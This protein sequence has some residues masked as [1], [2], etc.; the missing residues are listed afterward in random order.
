MLRTWFNYLRL[1]ENLHL[2][3]DT[4]A[5]KFTSITPVHVRSV[6]STTQNIQD[7]HSSSIFLCFGMEN[8]WASS[9]ST[10]MSRHDAFSKFLK[11][12]FIF[13]KSQLN[14]LCIFYLPSNEVGRYVTETWWNHVYVGQGWNGHVDVTRCRNKSKI[15]RS[16]IGHVAKLPTMTMLFFLSPHPHGMAHLQGRLVWPRSTF[17]PQNAL[18]AI[19]CS[20]C[21]LTIWEHLTSSVLDKGKRFI[22]CKVVTIIPVAHGDRVGWKSVD[23]ITSS[24]IA[25]HP[26]PW[27]LGQNKLWKLAPSKQWKFNNPYRK[28]M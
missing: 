12:F 3:S 26:L 7:H 21:R 24:L 17:H 18:R 22:C 28:W 2:K 27:H 6:C 16:A 14:V 15:K 11:F 19:V 23:A 25:Q 13:G 9:C 20:N 8:A 5:L 10:Y 4:A 1:P